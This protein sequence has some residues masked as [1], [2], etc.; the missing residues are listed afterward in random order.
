MIL[1]ATD[2]LLIAASLSMAFALRFGMIVPDDPIRSNWALFPAM[3]VLGVLVIWAMRLNHIKIHTVENSTVLRLASS[4][5]LLAIGAMAV[6]FMLNLSAPRSVP[7]IFGATFFMSSVVV[8]FLGRYSLEL[9]RERKNQR[10]PVAIYGAGNTGE[11][12]AAALTQNGENK[13]VCFIDDN[14]QLHGMIIGG[15]KVQPASSLRRLIKKHSLKRVLIAM[16]SASTYRRKEILDA[17]STQPIEV[18]ELPNVSDEVGNKSIEL[19]LKAKR[20]KDIT[21]TQKSKARNPEVLNACRGKTIFI[22][23]AGGA[24]G[25]ELAQQIIRFEPSKVVLFER[26]ETALL[27][28]LRR[29]NSLVARTGSET[30]ILAKTG[31]VGAIGRVQHLVKTEGVDIIINAAHYGDPRLSENNVFDVVSTNVLGPMNLAEVAIKFDVEQLIQLSSERVIAPKHLVDQTQMLAEK[32]VLGLA[33]KA[34]KTKIS[35]LRFG[36][37]AGPVGSIMPLLEHQIRNHNTVTLPD[38]E[39]TRFFVTTSKAAD[40]ILS[41]LPYSDTLHANPV[42]LSKGEP[43]K[44][45]GFVNKVIDMT[46]KGV[47]SDSNPYGVDVRFSGLRPGEMLHETCA[48]EDRCKPLDVNPDFLLAE[49]TNPSS[50]E[51]GLLMKSFTIALEQ[52]DEDALRHLLAT[53]KADISKEVLQTA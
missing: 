45:M 11:Q 35:F 10:V 32:L 13:P 30:E 19:M 40:M 25:Y 50:V 27:Q 33:N 22:A 7:L 2:M 49:E 26:N 28:I 38:P 16:P 47:R 3:L 43:R 6:S 20:F 8:H 24:V 42:H 48:C 18:M 44:V 34:R 1:F 46:G 4:A 41:A 37:T 21:A 52:Y 23:G 53:S 15:L 31:S 29:V 5:A 51:H 17:L 39:M 9:A 36:Q 12:L 14:R